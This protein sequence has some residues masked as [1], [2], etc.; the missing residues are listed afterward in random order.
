MVCIQNN[1]MQRGKPFENFYKTPREVSNM[2][3]SE[4]KKYLATYGE[5][6]YNT[7]FDFKIP[8]IIA[9][10]IN[11]PEK[12][13]EFKSGNTG[14]VEYTGPTNND[15]WNDKQA[16]E[17]LSEPYTRVHFEGRQILMDTYFNKVLTEAVDR[18]LMQIDRGGHTFFLGD[19]IELRL[20]RAFTRD[21]LQHR[22]FQDKMQDI[23][24][25]EKISRNA[26][27]IEISSHAV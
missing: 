15:T 18:E 11:R 23:K 3:N 22:A 12:G 6:N 14:N 17:H 24:N 26:S 20:S 27:D 2:S 16:K 13:L 19:L 8:K 1:I 21:S 5:I 9:S 7:N 25:F 4:I 10:P